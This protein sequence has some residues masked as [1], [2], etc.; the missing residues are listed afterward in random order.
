MSIRIH[1]VRSKVTRHAPPGSQVSMS[2][3]TY[4]AFWWCRIYRVYD[5]RVGHNVLVTSE[6]VFTSRELVKKKA[7]R[8][9]ER[10]A[11]FTLFPLSPVQKAGNNGTEKLLSTLDRVSC[12][13]YFMSI[14][15]IRCS[16][17]RIETTKTDKKQ[18]V[19]KSHCI[20]SMWRNNAPL[21]GY[22]G[23]QW[24]LFWCRECK[25][26]VR[27]S[28]WGSILRVSHLSHHTRTRH[29]YRD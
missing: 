7:A 18:S 1:L 5:F 22:R 4:A 9:G 10:L 29:Y 6:L 25:Q 3:H 23:G 26:A 11:T 15:I 17:R 14:A 16:V 28:S 19:A 20:F 13:N 24:R 21:L 8:V 2:R 27:T 12:T